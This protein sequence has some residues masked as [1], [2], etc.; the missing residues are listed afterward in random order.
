MSFEWCGASIEHLQTQVQTLKK[1]AK[2][3]FE[4]YRVSEMSTQKQN[5]LDHLCEAL[6]HVGGAE[7]LHAGVYEASHKQF[8]ATY[9]LS[10]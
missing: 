6:T 9:A 7:S 8:I 4:L 1:H 10:A 3:A 2:A 5:A